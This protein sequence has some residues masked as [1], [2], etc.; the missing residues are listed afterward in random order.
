VNF[1]FAKKNHLIFYTKIKYLQIMRKLYSNLLSFP[2]LL[3]DQVLF[4][5][6][7]L[8]SY[9]SLVPLTNTLLCGR[10][11]KTIL[12]VM[13]EWVS[14]CCLMPIQHFFSYIMA[15]SFSGGG[16][17]SIR[18]EPPTTWTMG[19]QL[20]NWFRV[21]LYLHASRREINRMVELS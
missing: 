20:V 15:T 2:L 16:S 3:L 10:S 14:D 8:K 1:L 4:I 17:R 13:Y 11:E 19:K 7:W 12:R 18:R 6:S 5:P 9:L 21:K